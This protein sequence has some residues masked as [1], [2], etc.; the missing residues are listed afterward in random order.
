V[1]ILHFVIKNGA[2]RFVFT[3]PRNQRRVRLKP[4]SKQPAAASGK[5]HDPI[6]NKT[7]KELQIRKIARRLSGKTIKFTHEKTSKRLLHSKEPGEDSSKYE[8]EKDR[9]QDHHRDPFRGRQHKSDKPQEDEAKNYE[10]DCTRKQKYRHQEKESTSDHNV[11]LSNDV[12][13][14]EKA[15]N[16][17]LDHQKRK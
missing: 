3:Q 2:K 16:G 4:L 10:R 7:I 1:R 11:F 5:S 8:H 9:T 6:T 14:S 12:L 17:K 15:H 13:P